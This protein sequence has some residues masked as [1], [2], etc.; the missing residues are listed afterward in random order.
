MRLSDFDECDCGDYRKHHKDGVGPC[1]FNGG[2]P[3]L[4][5]GFK[6]CLS[7]RLCRAAKEIPESHR[8]KCVGAT[9]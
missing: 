4:T 7:F 9:P 8:L 3:D 1:C 5:H 2:Y 6:D